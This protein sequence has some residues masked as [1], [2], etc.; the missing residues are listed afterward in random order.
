MTVLS[1]APEMSRDLDISRE[2]DYCFIVGLPRTGTKLMVNVLDGAQN[3]RACV[4]PEN[5][6]LGRAFLPGV[7]KKLRKFGDLQQDTN[8]HK[9]V[10]AMY[11][12]HFHGEY[13]DRLAD[14][15]LGVE[16]EDMLA[17]LLASDR[18]DKAI[19]RTLLHVNA[20]G[21]A[22]MLL[23]DKTGPHL[24]HVPTLLKWFP[25]AKIVHTLRD[26]RAILASEHKKRLQQLHYRS[27]QRQ[28]NGDYLG[29]TLL[30]LARPIVSI[31]IV[32]YITS[33]WLRAAHLHYQYQRRYPQNYILSRFEDLVSDPIVAIQRLCDFLGLEFDE[34]MLNP[35]HVDSSY[36]RK[37]EV[38]FDQQAL[39]RWQN[40]LSPWMKTWMHYCLGS[41]M[42]GLGYHA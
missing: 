18:S 12:R 4:A 2:Q 34:A 17:A 26:P 10:D 14:G 23:G 13:W 16:R 39:D 42:E 28:Q 30:K 15:S 9:L 35:P 38:G 20:T 27:T 6:F 36:E 41:Y 29:A 3:K 40:A 5:F 22:A 8:V 32:L 19:Y 31:L 11:S 7:R 25:T 21:K 24:Y 33:A 1:K 37:Q